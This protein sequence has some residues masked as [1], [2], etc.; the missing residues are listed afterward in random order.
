MEENIYKDP[1]DDYVKNSFE[2][3]ET[4]PSDDMWSRIENELPPADDKKPLGLPWSK[5]RWQLAAASVILLLFS[6]LLYVQYY[7]EEK[8]RAVNTTPQNTQQHPLHETD[9]AVETPKNTTKKPLNPV[10]NQVFETQTTEKSSTTA[11][12]KSN[13]PK[14]S[15]SKLSPGDLTPAGSPVFEAFNNPVVVVPQTNE[16]PQ[17]KKLETLAVPDTDRPGPAVAAFPLLQPIG[18]KEQSLRFTSHETLTGVPSVIKKFKEPSG[19]YAGV[20]ANPHIVIENAEKRPMRPRPGN[21]GPNP[22][23]LFGNEQ[24]KPKVATDYYI[25]VGKK[26]NQT[27]AIESG[28]GYLQLSRTAT[29][30]PWFQYRDGKFDSMQ[31]YHNRN[32]E[33]DLNTYGGSASVTLRT[34][35]NGNTSP[36]ETE[37]VSAE[38][39]SKEEIQ[40][41]HVPL[42]AVA[43]LGEGRLKAVLK[44][45]VLGSYLAKSDFKIEATSLENNNLRFDVVNGPLQVNYDRPKRFILGYE[46][47]AGVEFMLNKKIGLAM[48]PTLAGDFPRNDSQRGRLPNHTTFGLNMGINYWF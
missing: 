21:G 4:D 15:Q 18:Q 29:H 45:G 16:G 13:T 7:Y 24:E 48:S 40:I 8:L 11:H 19:W 2:H 39:T 44:A 34:E 6:R 17:E 35:E 42:L 23:H 1:M 38:I 20:Y 30:R 46:L 31:G 5:Y 43:R 47:S 3:F 32:F 25:R 9:Q 41:I 28:I 14:P 37:R 26:L 27:W 33:Y 36:G 12:E 22:R 10:N